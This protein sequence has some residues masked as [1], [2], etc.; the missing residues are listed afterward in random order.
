[1]VNEVVICTFLNIDFLKIQEYNYGRLL[2]GR[3]TK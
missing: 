1:M 2:K 3:W